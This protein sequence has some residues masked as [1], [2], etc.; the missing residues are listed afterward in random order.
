MN[1]CRFGF[2]PVN[3]PDPDPDPD[4]IYQQVSLLLDKN[5]TGYALDKV[6]YGFLFWHSRASNSIVNIPRTL[7]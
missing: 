1:D 4:P 5:D 3:Y 7:P 6:D 2:S